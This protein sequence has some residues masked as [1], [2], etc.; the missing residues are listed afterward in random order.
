M[1]I[2]DTEAL[3]RKVGDPSRRLVF[4]DYKIKDAA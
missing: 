2:T 4:K 1:K 3:F